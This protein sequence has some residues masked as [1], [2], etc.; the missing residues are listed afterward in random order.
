M[1]VDEQ[2]RRIERICQAERWILDTAY[3]HWLDVPLARA[4]LIVGLDYPRL[5]SLARLISRTM[6][7]IIDQQP[8]CN[9]N[10]ESLR[11]LFASNSIV[12][13]HFRSFA[14]KRQRMRAWA[15]DP[16]GSR[17]LLFSSPRRANAWVMTQPRARPP[18]E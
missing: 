4:E 8:I 12:V 7:R 9:G 3:R 18:G 13:W 17:V 6:R 10:H 15:A 14:R 2:R 16:D 11:T 5:I 1:P